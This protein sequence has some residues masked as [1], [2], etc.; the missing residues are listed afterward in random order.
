MVIEHERKEVAVT[1]LRDL[2]EGV[3][4]GWEQSCLQ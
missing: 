2:P 4:F 1:C 3:F